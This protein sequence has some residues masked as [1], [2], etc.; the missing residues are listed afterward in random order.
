M[1]FDATK[2]GKFVSHQGAICTDICEFAAIIANSAFVQTQC[3]DFA[4]LPRAIPPHNECVEENIDID[5][6]SLSDKQFAF[7]LD[8]V[9]E[10][11]KEDILSAY[12]E[13]MAKI[14]E[15]KAL[16]D[17]LHCVARGQQDEAQHILETSANAKT[18][19]TKPAS[20]T[21]YSSR[22]FDCTAYEYAYWAKDTHMCRMLEKY[23]AKDAETKA[24]MA[25][26]IDEMERIDTTTGQKIGLHYQ[27]AGSEYRSAHFDMKP[28]RDALQTY[29]YG[30]AAWDAA[31]NS[32]AIEKAWMDVGKAQRDV[33]AH[34]AQEYCTPDRSFSPLPSFNV[35]REDIPKEA[36][37]R[38]LTF[39]NFNT[40]TNDSWFPLVAPN[41]GLGFDFALFRDRACLR[42]VAAAMPPGAAVAA[43]DL[44]AIT[45]L[46]E[47]RTIDLTLS[48]DHLNPPASAPGMSM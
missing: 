42:S 5:I 33:P 40:Q 6:A 34:A 12:P 10:K 41:S 36:L 2:P 38:V 46:D 47:V 48:R 44:A 4:T 37:P 9:P 35:D 25:A 39:Y 13:R 17:F 16:P 3:R 26:R 29:V 21:D 28:L 11:T 43:G 32:D 22:T 19:L 31:E 30:Y 15:M 18:L 20:F 24:T 27:Q 23:I 45:R 14:Q 8:C 7:L 1:V